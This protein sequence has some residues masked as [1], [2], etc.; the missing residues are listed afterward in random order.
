MCSSIFLAQVIGCYL[1]LVGLVM[2]IHQQR[3]KK[4]ISDFLAHPTLIAMS[5][6]ICLI[7]GLLIVIEHN[8]WVSD[9]S[10]VVTMI[11]WVVLLQGIMRLFFPDTFVKTMKD[12]LGKTPYLVVSWLRI[13]VGLFL[14]WAG[15][16]Q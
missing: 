16:S 11:G 3:S 6:S 8:I 1:F 5:S 12:L 13:V 9:W 15:F 14:I 10:V 4:I 7:L 2:L